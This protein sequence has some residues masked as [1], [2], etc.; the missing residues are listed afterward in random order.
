MMLLPKYKFYSVDST[1]WSAGHRFGEVHKFDGSI[2]TKNRFKNRRIKD[3]YA[4]SNYN[5]YEWVKYS[6][7][8]DI[9]I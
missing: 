3:P 8:A 2:I 9:N 5:F 7:Y 6:E 1:T 4:L